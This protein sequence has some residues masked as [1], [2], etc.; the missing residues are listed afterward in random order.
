MRISVFI[1]Q[2]T[3]F[4]EKRELADVVK[5]WKKGFFPLGGNLPSILRFAIRHVMPPNNTSY[6]Y[7]MTYL[8]ETANTIRQILNL[9][10]PYFK[11]YIVKS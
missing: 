2:D 9:L 3:F 11:L 1:L 7:L 6:Y 10:T 8:S 5:A 4:K